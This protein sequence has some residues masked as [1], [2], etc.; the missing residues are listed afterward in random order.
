MSHEIKSKVDDP[1]LVRRRR[2]QLAAAAVDLFSER[3]YHPTTIRDIAERAEVSIG[4]IYQYVEDKEDLL[5]LALVQV[6]DSY[7]DQIPLALVGVAD[8]LERFCTAVRRYCRVNG[9]SVAATVLAYRETKSLRK[10]RRNLIKQKE[11]ET[12][13]LIAGCVR[14]CVAAGLFA[15]VDVEL[16]T[17]QIVMFS[18]AWALKAW[19]FAAAMDVEEYVDRG[20]RMMLRSVLTDAGRERLATAACCG[21]WM[22][23]T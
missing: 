2:D 22:E 1:D 8:P 9:E 17:Y 13:E 18:H 15:D 5:F 19:R 11:V 7:R 20:L 4:L 10:E 14:D 21:K 23:E 16:F 12:N 6:L 3:G